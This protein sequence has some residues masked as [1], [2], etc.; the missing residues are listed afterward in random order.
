MSTNFHVKHLNSSTLAKTVSKRLRVTENI[1]S[2]SNIQ[3][4]GYFFRNY[5][6]NPVLSSQNKQ[7]WTQLI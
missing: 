2:D 1:K 5:I 4:L 6:A 3:N 7:F